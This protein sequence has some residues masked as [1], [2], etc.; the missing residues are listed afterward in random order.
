MRGKYVCHTLIGRGVVGGVGSGAGIGGL[1]PS[2]ASTSLYHSLCGQGPF[3]RSLAV[4]TIFVTVHSHA[5]TDSFCHG[6]AWRENPMLPMVPPYLMVNLMSPDRMTRVVLRC[7]HTPNDV[8][9]PSSISMDA[10]S[11]LAQACVA[12]GSKSNIRTVK[13]AILIAIVT[14]ISSEPQRGAYPPAIRSG[15]YPLRAFSI[16]GSPLPPPK[17]ALSWDHHW[18]QRE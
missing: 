4:T 11:S 8:G 6:Y 9:T 10:H 12:R 1:V 18:W 16:A 14:S 2:S 5:M 7:G 3:V 13:Y 17:E 15:R